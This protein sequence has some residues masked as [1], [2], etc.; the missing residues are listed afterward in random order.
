MKIARALTWLLIATVVVLVSLLVYFSQFLPQRTIAIIGV[1][2][3]FTVN[4][5]YIFLRQH[6][7]AHQGIPQRRTDWRR[8]AFLAV[9]GLAAG[10]ALVMRFIRP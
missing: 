10:I 1:A 3:F 7:L 6:R 2:A 5:G 9:V 8:I 4:T